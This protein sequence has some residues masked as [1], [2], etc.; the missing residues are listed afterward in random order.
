M[1][2]PYRWWGTPPQRRLLGPRMSTCGVASRTGAHNNL[3]VR[4]PA[5]SS[6]WRVH[7][8]PP[9]PHLCLWCGYCVSIPWCGMGANRSGVCVG[10][11]GRAWRAWLRLLKQTPTMQLIAADCPCSPKSLETSAGLRRLHGNVEGSQAQYIA[12]LAMQTPTPFTLCDSNLLSVVATYSPHRLVFCRDPIQ[13]RNTA[14][15]CAEHSGSLDARK[16]FKLC[17]LEQQ[18]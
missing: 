12:R 6:L 2:T 9:A 13:F 8:V 7:H 11:G 1:D 15:P 4:S 14:L 17:E 10:G 16:F 3:P 5:Q 18:G